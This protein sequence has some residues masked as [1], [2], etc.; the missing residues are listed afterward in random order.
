MI[1]MFFAAVAMLALAG[2]NSMPGAVKDFFGSSDPCVIGA[3]LH[4]G[5]VTVAAPRVSADARRQE[6]IAYAAFTDYCSTGSFDK[7]TLQRALNAYTA[8][9]EEARK[10]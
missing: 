4:A 5:F 9:V 7:P 10:R 8:A 3:G 2:C 6:R 1:R